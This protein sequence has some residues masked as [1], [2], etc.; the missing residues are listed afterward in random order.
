MMKLYLVRHTRVDI[1]AGICYGQAD[2]AVADTFME[3]SVAVR[4]KLRG[5]YFDKVYSSPLL[6]CAHLA[7]ELADDANNIIYDHRL[8]ELNFGDWEGNSWNHIY[9]NL[10]GG[11]EWFADYEN[12]PCPNGE[13]Y[14]GLLHRV[15]QFIADLP[16]TEGNVLIITHAGVV[17]AFR[18][19]LENWPVKKAFDEP[20]GYGQ[21]TVIDFIRE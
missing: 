4:K 11:K 18:I 19:I 6:R 3:E 21:V 2:V 20:V 13:S 7:E 14:A 15:R 10:P 12:L 8:K 16:E 5:I 1:P 17:R 9:E